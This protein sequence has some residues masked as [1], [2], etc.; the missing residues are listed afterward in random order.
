MRNLYAWVIAGVVA[1]AMAG[2]ASAAET[3]RPVAKGHCH[4][5]NLQGVDL[6]G[7]DLNGIDLTLA[8]LQ[9]ANLRCQSQ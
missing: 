5:A 2:S 4:E 1:L 9:K 8:N 7:A 3:C 6:H